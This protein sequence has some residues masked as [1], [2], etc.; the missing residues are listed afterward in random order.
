MKPNRSRTALMLLAAVPILSA[1]GGAVSDEYELE[2]QPYQLEAVDGQD[3]LRVTLTESAA[4]RLGIE[5]SPVE[6]SGSGVSVPYDA[7]FLD[8]HGDFWVYTNPEPLVFV[9]APIEI[10]RETSSSAVLS[11]GPPAGTQ[12]VT[13]GV[14][15][16]YGSETEFGT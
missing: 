7:V 10:E 11:E 4:Q 1:C 8:A 14:P 6:A 5:T 15:E 2:Q 16:L 3:V 9:R 12:V 13:V